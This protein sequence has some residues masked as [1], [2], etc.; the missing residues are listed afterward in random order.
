M[1]AWVESGGERISPESHASGFS[2][3]PGSSLGDLVGT[4]YRREVYV[5]SD[6]S[7]PSHPPRPGAT[8]DIPW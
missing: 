1:R 5:E 2:A 4:F 8:P 6:I 7:Q 3:G